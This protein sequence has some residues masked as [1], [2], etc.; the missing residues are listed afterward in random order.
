VRDKE[1]LTDPRII[2][3]AV[4]GTVV[5]KLFAFIVMTLDG[6]HAGQHQEFDWPNVDEE[7]EEFSVRQLND[8]G[9]LV[10]GRATYEGMAAFWPTELAAAEAAQ[11]TE[12]MNSV[13]KVVISNSLTTADWNNTTVISGDVSAAV[14]EL[15][16][17]PGKDIAVFGS[18]NLTASLLDQNLVD[19]LRVM[20][21]PVLLGGGHSLLA[22]L[23]RR[24]H[25]EL[26]RTTTFRSGYVL[27]CY[28]PISN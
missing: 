28:R 27:L 14:T 15:K 25:L 23:S 11:I 8:I 4:G 16:E 5:R 6:Y 18:S 21:H 19:E 7:F 24:V 1:R 3:P 12:F 17:R 2:D 10:F 9:L 26:Q 22:G 20:V 13:P